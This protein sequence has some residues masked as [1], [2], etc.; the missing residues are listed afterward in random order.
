MLILTLG[1]V[2]CAQAAT[3]SIAF[4]RYQHLLTALNEQPTHADTI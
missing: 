4:L 1:Y 2:E 3:K